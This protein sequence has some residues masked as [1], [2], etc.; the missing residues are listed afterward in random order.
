MF[1]VL[2]LDCEWVS[3][4]GKVSPVSLLQLS[5]ISGLCVLVRLC[6]MDNLPSSLKEI[7]AKEDIYKVGVAVIDD[8]SKLLQSLAS[9]M[10]L[11]V[12]LDQDWSVTGRQRPSVRYV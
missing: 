7:L 4:D 1:P 2:G 6:V 11:G 12:K 10:I 3:Q 5:T 8:K 9:L